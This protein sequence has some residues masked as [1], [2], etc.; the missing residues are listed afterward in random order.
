MNRWVVENLIIEDKKFRNSRMELMGSFKVEDLKEMYH[1]PNPQDIYDSSYL[2]NF[3]NK[4]EEP[5]KM[6]QGWKVLENKFKFDKMG[7]YH[8]ASLANPYNYASAML[9]KLYGLP[10]N[11]KFSIEWILL[12]DACV[13]SHI[14]N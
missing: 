1:I 12:I 9:C 3:T 2:T 5:F 6:N 11:D 10:N 8:V 14:M 4:N 7:M 13:N